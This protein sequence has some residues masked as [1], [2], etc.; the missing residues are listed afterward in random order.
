VLKGRGRS[1]RKKEEVGGSKRK[2]FWKGGEIGSW[3]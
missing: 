3:D 2:Y 1:R